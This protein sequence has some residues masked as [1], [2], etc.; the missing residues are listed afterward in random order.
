MNLLYIGAGFVGACSAAASAAHGHDILVYDLNTD[1]VKAFASADKEKINSTLYEQGLADLIIEH[2]DKLQFTD[3]YADVIEYV[4]TCDAIFICVPTPEI[5]NTGETDLSYYDSAVGQLA[6][7]LAKR[8][9]GKQTQYMVL[10]NKST[11]PIDMADKTRNIL[12]SHGVQ[13]VGIVSNPEFLVEGN[14]VHGSLHPDRVVVGAWNTKDFE[15]MRKLY[16]KF[17]ESPE[18]GYLEVNP[19][20][21]EAGKL[22]ANFYLFNKLAVCFDVIG[23]TAEVFEDI[24]FESLRSIISSDKRIGNWGFYNSLYAGGSCL[25][26]DARSLSHQL[27]R[28]GV[29]TAI[30]DEVYAANKRQIKRFLDR[31]HTDAG[32]DWKGKRVALLGTTFKKNTN[33]TRDAAGYGIMEYVLQQEVSRVVIHD[34]MGMDLFKLTYPE[35]TT[36]TYVADQ[37]QAVENA[38]VII[39]A[40]DWPQFR[41]L[42]DVLVENQAKSKPLIMDGRRMLVHAYI[43]LHKAGYDLIAVGSPFLKGQA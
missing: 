18:V 42:G 10:I 28:T 36:V 37:Q 19:K 12:D 16:E 9:Q 7:A 20:E 34:P 40:T 3:S 4:D 30:V 25:N 26:K 1:R 32:F 22:L 38:D 14:A 2:R 33:D 6:Q 27:Q 13:H 43:E 5:A 41:L 21:A 31:A 15:Y 17:F 39:I 29:S 24:G 23:R 11:V 35:T 8:N